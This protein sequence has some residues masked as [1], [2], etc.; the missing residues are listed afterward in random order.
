MGGALLSSFT[1]PITVMGALHYNKLPYFQNLS[2]LSRLGVDQIKRLFGGQKEFRTWLTSQEIIAESI[3]NSINRFTGEHATHDMLGR[4]ANSVMKVSLMNAWTD[5][6]R[7]AFAAT[8][9]RNWAAKLGASWDQLDGWDRYLMTS[10]GLTEQDWAI[11]SKAQASIR[12]GE[13]FLTPR[14][15]RELGDDAV[16]DK[17]QAFITDETHFA[18]TQPDVAARA[19]VTMGGTQLG[20]FGG[21]TA[22]SVTQFMSFPMA[23]FSRHWRRML[24]TPQDIEGA[25]SGYRGELGGGAASKMALLAGFTTL[26]SLAGAVVVQTKMVASGRDPIEMWDEEGPNYKFWAKA[27]AQGGGF[28]FFGDFALKDPREDRPFSK[29]QQWGSIL[30]PTAGDIVGLGADVIWANAWKATD[31]ESTFGAD[32]L[33]WVSS[34]LPGNN[35]WQT[36]MLWERAVVHQFQD[37]LN[38]GYL[39][40]MKRRAQ[41]DWGVQYWWEPGELTPDRGPDIARMG[42][43]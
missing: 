37:A 28:G 18:I 34:N 23:V 22:R 43:E 38:P 19:A 15:V 27:V 32:A 2:D 12:G 33:G 41:K 5:A 8:M 13:R 31:N 36:R 24:E 20:T 26:L 25:P 4:V 11:I 16:A 40:R 29:G 3:A 21:E 30:G 10:K 6:W 14:G 9:M 42:G 35:L 17:W 1:D 7:G 39:Q